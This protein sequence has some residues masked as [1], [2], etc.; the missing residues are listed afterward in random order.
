MKLLKYFVTIG[1]HKKIKGNFVKLMQIEF[2]HSNVIICAGCLRERM[3][4]FRFYPLPFTNTASLKPAA[5][6]KGNMSWKL[7][8]ARSLL[9]SKGY[10]VLP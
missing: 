6:A 7:L 3:A 2:L 5:L 8:S 4:S 10:A 9:I 1:V